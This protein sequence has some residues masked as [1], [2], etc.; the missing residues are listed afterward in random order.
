LV[1][2]GKFDLFLV[3]YASDVKETS[4]TRYKRIR[5][6]TRRNNM[7]NNKKTVQVWIPLIRIGHWTLV[8][9][10][11]TAYL[12]E[13]DFMTQHVWAGYIVGA[14]VLIRVLWGF[15]GD[16]YARFSN[17]VDSPANIFG[18]LKNL[19]A[20][21]PQHYIG[22]NPAGGAMV[23]ALLLSL[24]AT[25]WTGLKL[26]AV[27]DNKGPLASAQQVQTQ[28]Q[29]VGLISEAKA[30]DNEDAGEVSELANNGHKVNKQ[31]EEY[32]EELHELFANLTLFL[33]FLHIIGIIVS[34]YIDKENLVKTMLTGKK[35]IDDTYQ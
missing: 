1:L 28:I 22:H 32:W 8:I 29:L 30:E 10:F 34:S 19:V 14:Y 15:V 24:A 20:R 12:T 23:V 25:T 31:D 18:Y 17:F 5:Q 11:F 2:T 16:K 4:L 7:T 26:Y 27:E 6:L 3:V 13:D 33:V 35:E 9:A 21:K